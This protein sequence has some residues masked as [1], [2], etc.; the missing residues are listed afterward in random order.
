MNVLLFGCIYMFNKLL[1][2][3]F[4]CVSCFISDLHLYVIG[5]IAVIL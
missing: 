5:I 2:S 4:L 3:I 1:L